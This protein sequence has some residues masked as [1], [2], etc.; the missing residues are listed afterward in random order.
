MTYSKY[1]DSRKLPQPYMKSV[2]SAKYKSIAD[3]FIVEEIGHIDLT[4]TG[5]HL[6]MQ[7]QKKGMNTTYVAKELA[8]W[9]KI[10]Q[11]DVGFSGLK[12]RQAITTQW[13]SLRIPTSKLP[14]KNFS[15]ANIN[16]QEHITVLQQKWHNKKLNRGT[17]KFNRF[18]ITLRDV[19]GDIESVDNTISNIKEFGVPNYF[20]NQRF[21]KDGNNINSALEWFKFGTINKRN[22]KHNKDLQSILLSTARS[23]IFNQILA[24]RVINNSWNKALT[25]EIYNLSGTGS[26]FTNKLNI[27][28][29]NRIESLDIHPTGALWGIPSKSMPTESVDAIEKQVVS[30][31]H[32]LT[33]LAEGLVNKKVK[34]ARRP[35]R[36]LISDLSW[37]WIE[38]IETQTSKNI[39][40]L[41]F[42]LP[43]GSF[44]TTVLHSLVD[45]LVTE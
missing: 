5:E 42:K 9:A 26:I 31:S 38:D 18:I 19:Q 15:I 37:Q 1:T 28:I 36:L 11:R 23:V 44:A 39:L 8:K 45:H 27:E 24:H 34:H 3:D 14:D 40:K 41:D 30:S 4:G 32:I 33:E 13:F 10:P 6:W 2:I 35:L 12:D 7:I 16:D 22:I 21:G 17:H 20:G 43:T 25:G 29:K